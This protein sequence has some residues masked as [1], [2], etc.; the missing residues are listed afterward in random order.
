MGIKFKV[1]KAPIG[2]WIAI[3]FES[4]NVE[5]MEAVCRFI[6]H[7]YA[8][9]PQNGFPPFMHISPKFTISQGGY[10]ALVI[11]GDDVEKVF[12]YLN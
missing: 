1:T 3:E 8:A 5:Q 11:D 12:G 7:Y 4:L 10:P 2:S 9:T 6:R